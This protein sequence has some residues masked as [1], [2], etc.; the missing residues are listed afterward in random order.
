MYLVLWKWN[1]TLKA[2]F[3][4]ITFSLITWNLR[5]QSA[6]QSDYLNIYW[7]TKLD[8]LSEP[9]PYLQWGLGAINIWKFLLILFNKQVQK[10]L[11]FCKYECC[12][13][14]V[15][16]LAKHYPSPTTTFMHLQAFKKA[17]PNM[18]PTKKNEDQIGV[19]TIY[20]SP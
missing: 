12:N 13:T 19:G 1:L 10:M 8:F 2:I 11:F 7:S 9:W 14:I 4:W 15:V 18:K 20:T 6:Q 3:W 16:W 5:L 17:Q